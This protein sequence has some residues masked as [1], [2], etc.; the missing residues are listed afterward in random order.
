MVVYL[1]ALCVFDSVQLF[2][3]LPIIYLGDLRRY[4]SPWDGLGRLPPALYNRITWLHCYA[5]RFLYPVLMAAN[6][7]S[8]WIVTLIC[9]QR[10]FAIC[11]PL[12]ALRTIEIKK[13]LLASGPPSRPSRHG[14]EWSC[15]RW[16]GYMMTTR[17]EL[18]VM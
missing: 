4:F 3:S 17:N 16:L 1:M 5:T 11:Y 15:S 9:V 2:L 10:F 12:S 7:G 8:I 18:K 14:I 6:Y 13:V